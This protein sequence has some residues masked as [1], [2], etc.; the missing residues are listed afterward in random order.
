MANGY[1]DRA[2]RQLEKQIQDVNTKVAA[3]DG[4]ITGAIKPVK[5]KVDRVESIANAAKS[6]INEMKQA[7]V[8]KDTAQDGRLAELERKIG[9]AQ[10]AAENGSSLSQE[11]LKR[12]EREYKEAVKTA[13]QTAG[14]NAMQKSKQNATNLTGDTLRGS[15]L[16]KATISLKNL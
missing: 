9:S 2:K 8:V 6:E 1:T 11:E 12:V 10:A 13:V 15:K 14:S 5:D 7:Q 3:V 16:T 4:T